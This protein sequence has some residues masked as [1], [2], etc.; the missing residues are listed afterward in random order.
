MLSI[1]QPT[2]QLTEW[3]IDWLTN[4]L[5]IGRLAISIWIIWSRLHHWIMFGWVI[6]Y[7]N[8][9]RK[10]VKWKFEMDKRSDNDDDNNDNDDDW[11]LMINDQWS[12]IRD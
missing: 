11:W 7:V 9:R 2:N 5:T 12:M 6:I 8:E 1:N 3:L 10:G 4:Q